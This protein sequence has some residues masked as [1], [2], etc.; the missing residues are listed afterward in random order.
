MRPESKGH[1]SNRVRV[2]NIMPRANILLVVAVATAYAAVGAVSAGCGPKIPIGG[3][4]LDGSSSNTVRLERGRTDAA[5]RA[6]D[7]AEAGDYEGATAALREAV[8]A[9][10][11]DDKAWFNLGVMQ[12]RRGQ[13]AQAQESYRRA[14]EI[15]DRSK[16]K[17]CEIRV[18]RA[19]LQV[20]QRD[21]RIDNADGRVLPGR[22]GVAGR[23]VAAGN[24]GNRPNGNVAGPGNAGA[25]GNW[26]GPVARTGTRR[27][28]DLRAPDTVPPEPDTGRGGV[29]PTRPAP[30]TGGTAGNP[31]RNLTGQPLPGPS[32]RV[33]IA[34]PATPVPTQPDA[35]RPADPGSPVAVNPSTPAPPTNPAPPSEPAKPP[36]P[37]GQP[38]VLVVQAAA[39]PG[40]DADLASAAAQ[41]ATGVEYRLLELG[42]L[43][44][45]DRAGLSGDQTVALRGL[46]A[47]TPAERI[48]KIGREVGADWVVLVSARVSP[49]ADLPNRLDGEVAGRAIRCDRGSEL[50]APVGKHS[51][52]GDRRETTARLVVG[53]AADDSARKLQ[54]AILS[55]WGK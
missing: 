43:L 10:P 13:Y 29:V 1:V 50:N 45:V 31:G 14:I 12:E 42:G 34:P 28:A 55:D 25:P 33:D 48:A 24:P 7:L 27:P 20:A 15:D 53:R 16:Y 35:G 46:S 54:S 40:A 39:K 17:E 51:A 26:G 23:D 11:R 52:S 30:G 49:Q 47:E 22:G 9:D 41:A 21:I 6:N 2:S 19:L 5:R 32:E 3:R 8:K 36:A 38:R 4:N 18:R 37:R 44:L